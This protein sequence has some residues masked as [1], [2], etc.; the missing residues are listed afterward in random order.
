MSRPANRWHIQRL[1]KAQLRPPGNGEPTTTEPSNN[2]HNDSNDID[3]VNDSIPGA[4][5]ISNE[6]FNEHQIP[7]WDSND[8]NASTVDQLMHNENST[9]NENML[10]NE[11]DINP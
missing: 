7:L 4:Y 11:D 8:I 9:N 10:E 2:E 1:R 3:D 5:A 6:P